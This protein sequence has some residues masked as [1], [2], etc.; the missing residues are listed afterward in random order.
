MNFDIKSMKQR[1]K[2]LLHTTKPNVSIIGIIFLLFTVIYFV[3]SFLLIGYEVKLWY[4]YILI[5]ELFHI[6]IRSSYKLYCLNAVREEKTKIG[7]IFLAFKENP[8][9]MLLSGIVRDIC[10]IV[11]FCLCLIELVFPFYWFRFSVYIMKD[12]NVNL[13]KAFGKSRKLLKGHFTEIVKID[14]NNLGWYVLF[15]FT[16]GIAGIYVKPFTSLVYAE[17]YEHLKAQNE[18]FG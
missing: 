1:A 13:F 14:I 16:M 2:E 6:M 8:L 4:V 15:L 12:E 11:G 17:Y 9:N 5:M 18:L 10:Y 7:D 3:T